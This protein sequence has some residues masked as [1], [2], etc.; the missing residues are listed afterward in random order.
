MDFFYANRFQPPLPS[1]SISAK[2]RGNLIRR[3]MKNRRT[4]L[5]ATNR[6][7]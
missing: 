1:I 4:A 2:K 5:G 3:E 6:L 7:R